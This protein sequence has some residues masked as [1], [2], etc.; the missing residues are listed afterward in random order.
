MKKMTK[1]FSGVLAAAMLASVVPVSAATTNDAYVS[2]DKKYIPSGWEVI[3][4]EGNN[5]DSNNNAD[6]LRW[7]WDEIDNNYAASWTAEEDLVSIN[8]NTALLL[9]KRD[10]EKDKTS[11]RT[12][13]LRGRLKETISE[14]TYRLSLWYAQGELPNHSTIHQLGK[15]TDNENSMTG[16]YYQLGTVTNGKFTAVDSASKVNGKM[17]EDTVNK[18]NSTGGAKWRYRTTQKLAENGTSYDIVLGSGETANAIHFTEGKTENILLDNICLQKVTTD[19]YGNEVLGEN[20]VVNGDFESGSSINAK[21]Y[22]PTELY[23][24]NTWTINRQENKSTTLSE[25]WAAKNY[26]GVT[27]EVGRGGGSSLFV[28]FEDVR[29]DNTFVNVYNNA[30]QGVK[31]TSGATYVQEMWVK[32]HFD[33]ELL[34][35]PMWINCDKKRVS[36]WTRGETDS[37]GWT[38]YSAEFEFDG[39]KDATYFAIG[40]NQYTNLYIDDVKLYNKADPKTNLI[41]DGGFED[42]KVIDT[43][44]LINPI[45]YSVKGGSAATLSWTNPEN[46]KITDIKVKLDG[47]EVSGLTIDKT[48]GAYNCVLLSGLTDYKVYTAT[49]EE[50]INGS[51]SYTKSLE[52]YTND[53]NPREVIQKTAPMGGWILDKTDNNKNNDTW[54]YQNSNASLDYET[55]H[56]GK[57]SLRFDANMPETKNNLYVAAEQKLAGL[58][59]GNKYKL[60]FWAKSSGSKRLLVNES[61]TYVDEAGTTHTN[62]NQ[63]LKTADGEEPAPEWKNFEVML[64]TT[65]KNGSWDI[66]K[67]GATDTYDVSLY[68]LTPQM[69]GSLWIDDVQLLACDSDEDKLDDA[70]NLITNGGFE[71]DGKYVAERPDFKDKNG[72]NLETLKGFSG[73]VKVTAAIKNIAAGDNFPAAIIIGLYKNSELVSCTFMDKKLSQ[74]AENLPSD[75]FSDTVTVPA[76]EEGSDDTYSIKVM[77]WKGIGSMEPLTSSVTLK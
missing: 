61:A 57:S 26:A 31:L 40:A 16:L 67:S 66:Y 38:K 55:Y 73:D 19:E 62:W 28:H 29:A 48:S 9:S 68:I 12:M 54:V 3:Y 60:T 71:F 63:I 17:N 33:Y 51:L 11:N 37:E 69:V 49:L 56:G 42:N 34:A 2:T 23:A 75:R 25:E 20:L 52:F 7:T 36:L 43:K 65:T 30:T 24:S 32:G 59:R 22:E 39:K 58:S 41:T 14:G 15:D 10:W 72:N 53:R 45:A 64:D 46:S 76:V 8:G 74:T 18:P 4:N 13:E 21:N 27:A 35:Y 47:S 70:T 6:Y 50:Y 77:Y 44:S 1:L 5:T